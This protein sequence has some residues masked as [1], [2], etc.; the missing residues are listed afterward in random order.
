MFGR[1]RRIRKGVTDTLIGNDTTISGNL[2]FAGELAVMG[3]V[4]GNILAEDS[5]SS[6]VKLSESARVEGEIRVP[7]VLINGVVIGD[8][9]ATERV[10][11]AKNARI[12]GSVYYHLI[13]MEMGAEVNGAMVHMDD[14]SQGRV[15][16]GYEPPATHMM[17]GSSSARLPEPADSEEH[18]RES[19]ESEYSKISSS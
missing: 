18:V 3:T 6:V 4:H 16:L 14:H 2:S 11:L 7:N 1:G 10:Q 15:S 8:V 9:H 19:S 13:E 17:G 5:S 12:H